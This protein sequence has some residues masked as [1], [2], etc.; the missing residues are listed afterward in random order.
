MNIVW[1]DNRAFADYETW[2]D[3]KEGFYNKCNCR[4]ADKIYLSEMMLKDAD[5]FEQACKV[6]FDKWPITAIVHLTNGQIN[7][8]A[9]IGHAASFLVNESC[10]DCTVS[11][12]HRLNSIQQAI[13]ND[14]ADMAVKEWL[15]SCEPENCQKQKNQ[16]GLTF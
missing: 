7:H 8:K 6:V 10:E 15:R 16:L 9:W 4:K 14:V 3:Y 11:A 12:W 5:K 2:E 13:A 1:V